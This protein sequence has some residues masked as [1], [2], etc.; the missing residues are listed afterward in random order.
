MRRIV[1]ALARLDDHWTGDV[2]GV[3]CLFALIPVGL[4]WAVAL[5]GSQ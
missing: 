4:F 2:L 3:L 1:R 5:G